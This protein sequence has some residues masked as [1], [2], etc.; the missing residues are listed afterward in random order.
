M[1]SIYKKDEPVVYQLLTTALIN[2]KCSHAYLFETRNQKHYEIII[3]FIEEIIC[4]FNKKVCEKNNCKICERI[5]NN[6]YPEVKFIEADGMWI[7]KQQVIDLK[8]DFATKPIEGS[9]KIYVIKNCEKLNPSSANSIL[10]FLEEPEEDIVAILTSENIDSVM[11]TI[12]SRCQLIKFKN[13]NC[14]IISNEELELICLKFIENVEIKGFNALIDTAELKNYVL[15]NSSAEEMFEYIIQIYR[16]IF[17]CK[18][19]NSKKCNSVIIE[20]ANK[21]TE[22]SISKKISKI[23]ILKE[24]IKYNVNTNLL[25][26]KFLLEMDD[27]K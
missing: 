2:N 1:L 5:E 10:K 14:D 6:N 16:D 25:I 9:K 3:K 18:I 20:L 12:S 8:N 13:N 26:D 11:K 4:P 19:N 22:F 24:R 7:K 23:L 15:K 17:E 21:N 27:D